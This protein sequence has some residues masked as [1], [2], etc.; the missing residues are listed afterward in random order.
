RARWPA[1]AHRFV[2]EMRIATW[3]LN[4]AW[5]KG[6]ASVLHALDCEVLLLTECPAEASLSG[7]SKHG[8]TRR[9]DTGTTHWAAIL[10][11]RVLR[12]LPD[13][14]PAS[15]AASIGE[16]QFL[17]TVLPWPLARSSWPWGSTA[18]LP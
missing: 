16:V 11:R 17:A 14:H 7:F 6:H 12:P 5:S 18:H 1:E 10:S 8:T 15:A 3:N 13:P 2:C 4:G 9:I